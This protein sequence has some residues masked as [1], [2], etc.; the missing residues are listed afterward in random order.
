[1]SEDSK[2]AKWMNSAESEL[3]NKD[4]FRYGLQKARES[5]V[6]KG[7]AW[8]VAGYNDVI[9]WQT[10]GINNTIASCGTAIA[11]RQTQLLKKL[12]GH[13]VFCLDQDEAGIKAMLK[14]VPEFMKM[15]FR[16]QLANLPVGIDPDDYVRTEGANLK[17]FQKTANRSDGFKFL[18]DNL[19][20]DK[21]EVGIAQE[22]KK[23]TEIIAKIEDVSMQD[24]YLE[25]LSSESKTKLTVL[26]KYLKEH[27][28]KDRKSVV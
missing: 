10:H 1:L 12:C 25:W 11:L 13:I 19:F 16:V 6:K 17:E 4:T 9:A 2:Y 14:Y 28:V 20:K 23:L 18:M 8:R 21:D 27:E 3:Y 22:A 15:G 24:L 5:T 26:K 7:E